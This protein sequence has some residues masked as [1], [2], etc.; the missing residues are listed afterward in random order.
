VSVVQLLLASGGSLTDTDAVS[1]QQT[2]IELFDCFSVFHFVYDGNHCDEDDD[3]DEDGDEG[4]EDDDGDDDGGDSDG[5]GDN[6]EDGDDYDDGDE[7]DDRAC[8]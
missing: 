3:G 1:G 7:D 4:D 5:D 2:R 6:V 8:D